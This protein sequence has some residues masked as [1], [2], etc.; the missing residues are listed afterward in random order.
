[1]L[2]GCRGACWGH[3]AGVEYDHFKSAAKN[4]SAVGNHF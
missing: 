1:M 4:F 2:V 3:I